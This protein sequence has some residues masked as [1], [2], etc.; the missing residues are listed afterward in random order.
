[1]IH[2]GSL[3]NL[4]TKPHKTMWIEVCPLPTLSISIEKTLKPGG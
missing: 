4:Q 3:I 1:M 2:A